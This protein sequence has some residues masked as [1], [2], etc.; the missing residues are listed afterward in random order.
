MLLIKKLSKLFLLF[1]IS[2]F[3]AIIAASFLLIPKKK[4]LRLTAQMTR[5]WAGTISR[6]IGLKVTVNG[7]WEKDKGFFIVSNHLGYIDILAHASVFPM[8]FTPKADV[9]SWPFI[10]WIIF[11]SRP[12]WIRRESKQSVTKTIKELTLTLENNINLIVYPEGTSSDG[13][14]GPLP[15]KS[16][17]F[18]TP[19]QGQFP[20]LPIFTSYPKAGYEKIHWFG[21]MSF[22]PHF[23]NILEMKEIN[24]RIDILD[25]IQPSAAASRKELASIV[26]SQILRKYN[27]INRQS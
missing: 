16:S 1:I 19:I 7:E 22:V 9:A 15:F 23:W 18:E 14:N 2:A 25:I 3:L 12:V 5:F 6:I 21:D 24:A 17:L 11:T 4:S 8:R 10:G 26:H 27:E 13:K 20:I